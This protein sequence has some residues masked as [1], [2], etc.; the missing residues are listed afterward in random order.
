MRGQ[1]CI[2]L[3]CRSCSCKFTLD[4]LCCVCAGAQACELWVD[5]EPTTAPNLELGQLGKEG[6]TAECSDV[7]RRSFC[8]CVCVC[9][10]ERERE[11]QREERV[12]VCVHVCE[13]EECLCGGRETERKSVCVCVCVCGETRHF[14]ET[15]AREPVELSERDDFRNLP[16]VWPPKTPMELTSHCFSLSLNTQPFSSVRACS[17]FA[18]RGFGS[19]DQREQQTLSWPFKISWTS[20]TQIQDH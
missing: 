17:H 9:E 10:R 3:C 5:F 11:R 20:R 15:G 18:E 1:V 7:F 16:W 2:F 12:C 14:P 8:L 4:A 6:N 13:R 19:N